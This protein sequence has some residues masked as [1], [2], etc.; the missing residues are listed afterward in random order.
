MTVEATSPHLRSTPTVEATQLAHARIVEVPAVQAAKMIALAFVTEPDVPEPA[1]MSVPATLL[2]AQPVYVGM[3][4]P[5][6]AVVSE[7]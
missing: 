7:N 6:S 3:W 1:F 5:L 4:E 2:R